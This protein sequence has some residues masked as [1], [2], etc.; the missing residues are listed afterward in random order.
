[1]FEAVLMRENRTKGFFVAFDFSGDA[2]R[3]IDALFR[4]EHR[5]IVPPH[6]PRDPQRYPSPKNWCKRSAARRLGVLARSF[7]SP[8]KRLRSG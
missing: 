7:T 1:M 6:G 4:R 8:E 3:E 2:L 5:V